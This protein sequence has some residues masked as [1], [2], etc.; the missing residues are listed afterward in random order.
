[1]SKIDFA[2]QA[3]HPDQIVDG[4]IKSTKQWANDFQGDL[5]GPFDHPAEAAADAPF[6]VAHELGQ[7]PSGFSVEDPGYTGRG[8]YATEADRELWTDATITLRSPD[9]T[10]KHITVRVRRRFDG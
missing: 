2:D 8:V 6:Q 3:N 1:M 7:M 4:H 9:P 5:I 10:N